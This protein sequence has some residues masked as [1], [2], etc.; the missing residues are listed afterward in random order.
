VGVDSLC[1]WHGAFRVRRRGRKHVES[2]RH[3]GDN[4]RQYGNHCRPICRIGWHQ[5][6]SIQRNNDGAVH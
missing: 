4:W 1:G 3:S 6:A 2:C 5:Q